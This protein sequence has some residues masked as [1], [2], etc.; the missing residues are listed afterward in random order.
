MGGTRGIICLEVPPSPP[1]PLR[2]SHFPHLWHAV[3]TKKET[4]GSQFC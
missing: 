4:L 1:P 2:V 3:F